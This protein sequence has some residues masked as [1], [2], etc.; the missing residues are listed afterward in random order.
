M[1]LFAPGTLREAFRKDGWAILTG[2][3]EMNGPYDSPLNQNAIRRLAETLQRAGMRFSKVEGIYRG[4]NQG[5]N[6]LVTGIS[7]RE[8]TDLAAEYVQESVLLNE[9]LLMTRG[10]LVSMDHSQTLVGRDAM[11][12]EFYTVLPGGLPVSCRL[13]LN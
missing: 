1:E 10:G 3:C 4:V 13:N 12:Q 6:Y 8:A 7:P 5:I 2:T 9:G 11:R